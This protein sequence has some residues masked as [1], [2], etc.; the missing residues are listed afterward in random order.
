LSMNLIIFDLD[1]TLY[2]TRSTITEAVRRTAGDL[3]LPVPGDEVIV[4]ALGLTAEEYCRTL[5]PNLDDNMLEDVR[6]RLS[7]YERS[8]IPSAAGLFPGTVEMLRWFH[9][10]GYTLA[11]CSSGS[12]EYVRL[13]LSATGID[14]YFSGIKSASDHQDKTVLVH[15][16][17]V[18]FRPETALLVGDRSFDFDAAHD[19]NLIAVGV[20]YGF[21]G[22]EIKRADFT[23]R[24]ADDLTGIVARCDMF[25]RIEADLSGR[26]KKRPMVIGINGIDSSGKTE[27]AILLEIYLR[28]RGR[29]VQTVHLDDFHNS[30]EIRRR[31]KTEIEA[32]ISNAFNLKLLMDRILEPC[33]RGEKLDIEL[34]L[35]DLDS[36]TLGIKRNY[37]IDRQ[38]VVLVE[39]VLLYRDELDGFFDYRIFL[40]IDFSEM[41]RRVERRD[42][43]RFGPDIVEKYKRKYIPIQT[44]YLEQHQPLS[45]CDLIIDNN[46][47]HRPRI[48]GR[49][50]R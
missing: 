33:R 46:D 39:G 40:D 20:E 7:R 36:D 31:G 19:N 42:I 13:V 35:L 18:E 6:G 28:A 10:K 16:L 17:L 41:L 37:S 5:F 34:T 11:I 2:D 45:H 22:G 26:D 12:G 29:S 43:D 44:W 15:E 9:E 3:E 23:A 14:K 27:F 21:G 25:A 50:G 1:G 48:K 8:L 30:K 32:Y 47:Y 49:P 4:A 24:T 38:T